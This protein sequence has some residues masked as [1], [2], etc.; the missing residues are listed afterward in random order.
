MTGR[1]SR[2][3]FTTIALLLV[4]ATIGVGS[5]LMR[6]ARP[7]LDQRRPTEIPADA[8]PGTSSGNRHRLTHGASRVLCH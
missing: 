3:R 5:A 4:T 1:S 2:V 7:D 6:F 8:R